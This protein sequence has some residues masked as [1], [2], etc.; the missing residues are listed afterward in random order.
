MQQTFKTLYICYFGLRE[1]LVQTQVLPYLRAIRDGGLK[2]SLLTFEPEPKKNWSVEEV[3][4]ERKKL[5][6][7]GIDWHFLT[8]HKRPSA[9]ATAFDIL[10]GAFF[11]WNM[12][13]R[14]HFDVLHARV[15]VPALMG[16]IAK[17]FTYGRKPKLLFDIRGFFPEEYTD[18]G[19][20]K[21]DGLLYRTAKRVEKWLLNYSDAFVVLTEKAR[22]ILFPESG[23]NGFDKFGRPVEVITCCVDLE[24][25]RVANKT[26]R[27]E[28][29][30]EHDL[31][32]RRVITYIGSLGSWY[33]ADEMADFMQ[34]ARELDDSVFAMILTQS[35][36]EIMSERLTAR[37]FSKS[38]FMVKRVSHEEIPRYLSGSD[39]AISFIKACYSKLSSSPTKIAEYLAAGIPIVVN[40]GVGDVAE[41]VEKYQVGAVIDDFSSASY[42]KALANLN[43]FGDLNGKCREAAKEEFDLEEVGGRKYRLLYKKLLGESDQ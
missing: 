26:S 41:V 38:D 10:A 11:V 9:P 13:R 39:L 21:P 42:K 25:F 30:R 36:P 37:G 15:H 33:L 8:Y 6:E 2:V 24:R 1:P 35:V 12:N 18:G 20:W 27:D 34:S 19:V 14:V 22:E 43:D 16:A 32:N 29:R 5:A 7:E 28:I 40:R 3:D 23:E 31:E 4:Y 17:K